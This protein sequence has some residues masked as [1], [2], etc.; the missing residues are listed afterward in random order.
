MP[1]SS[2]PRVAR[3]SYLLSL[4]CFGNVSSI[5]V[6]LGTISFQVLS[7]TLLVSSC[8]IQVILLEKSDGIMRERDSRMLVS[9][10]SFDAN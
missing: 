9:C 2:R 10:R 8:W 7:N 5:R 6:T 1:L 4:G 3:P